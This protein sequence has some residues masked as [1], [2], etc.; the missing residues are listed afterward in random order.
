[1]LSFLR[2][3]LRGGRLFLKAAAMTVVGNEIAQPRLAG[4]EGCARA[5]E[6]HATRQQLPALV[7]DVPEVLEQATAASCSS[8]EEERGLLWR[9]LLIGICVWPGYKSYGAL[10]VKPIH[11]TGT[12]RIQARVKMYSIY[13]VS[14]GHT[15]QLTEKVSPAALCK[16]IKFVYDKK[17]SII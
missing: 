17:Y 2:R 12:V 15:V 1:M 4:L 11:G 8:V 16:K 9:L 13:Y 5:K 3:Q 7:S 10:C 6:K 14:C